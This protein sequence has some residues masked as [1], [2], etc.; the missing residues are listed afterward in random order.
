MNV[1]NILRVSNLFFPLYFIW[2][3]YKNNT[4]K[5]EQKVALLD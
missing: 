1:E 2:S 4:S 3:K 5:S